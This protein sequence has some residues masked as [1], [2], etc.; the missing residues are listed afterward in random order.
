MKAYVDLALVLV[1][2]TSLYVVYTSRLEACIKAIA[3]QGAALAILPI[4]HFLQAPDASL[5]HA[6]LI[7]GNALLLKAALIPWLLRR[8]MRA[9]KVRR[10]VE[11]FVSTHASVLI[12]AGLV[13]AAFVLP[14]RLGLPGDVVASVL[15][16]PVALATLLLGHRDP[17]PQRLN[18]FLRSGASPQDA[19]AGDDVP[20]LLDRAMGHGVRDRAG[21]QLE[22]REAAAFERRQQ[23]HR[24]SIGAVASGSARRALVAKGRGVGI[25]ASGRRGARSVSAWRGAR[26]PAKRSHEHDPNQHDLK[27]RSGA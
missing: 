27:R 16:L 24:R 11:P 18:A 21:G 22:M 25:E 17:G 15:Y 14:P 20:D 1:L 13:I 19:A 10:E 12:A 9:T 2:L 3:V 5:F 23:T 8:A 4:L 7:G 6:L 26:R